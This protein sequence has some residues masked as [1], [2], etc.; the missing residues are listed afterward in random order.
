MAVK[1]SKHTNIFHSK[2]RQNVT[3]LGIFGLETIYHLA[4]LE[5]SCS[6]IHR[7]GSPSSLPSQH[8]LSL[9]SSIYQFI[10]IFISHSIIW[11]T[12]RAP[13]FFLFSGSDGVR[14]GGSR[15]ADR[16]FMSFHFCCLHLG[17]RR[18]EKNSGWSM[19]W[20]KFFE[21]SVRFR[22]YTFLHLIVTEFASKMNFC[23]NF[24][25]QTYYESITLP[26]CNEY[27]HITL[28]V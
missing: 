2:S 27:L 7:Y 24:V 4:T 14:R 19:F 25:I 16:P 22:F 1:Y 9:C 8:F 3:H 21:D 13:I 15:A 26:I 12:S 17:P 20:S 5:M 11:C 23:I 28:P 6:R 10:Y 18:A